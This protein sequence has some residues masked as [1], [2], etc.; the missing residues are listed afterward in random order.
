MN[1]VIYIGAVEGF[2]AAKSVLEDIAVIR[3]V[4]ADQDSVAEAMQEAGALLDASMKVRITDEMIRSAPGLKVISCAT[5]GSD[6]IERRVLDVRGI[7]VHT[8]RDDPD[9]IKNITPAAELS[10]ALLMACARRLPAAVRHVADG[11]WTREQFPGVMLKGRRL[12]L[13]GCGR[14]GGWMARYARAF[15]MEAVGCDPHL[16]AW[17][18]NIRKVSLT[19]L[20]QTSDFISVHVHLTDETRGLISRTLIEKIKPGAVF[21]NTSRGAI[22]DENALLDELKSGRIHGVGLDVLTG[23]PDVA[24]HPLVKYSREH[25]NVLITP[26]CGGFS[27]DA[28]RVVCAHAAGKIRAALTDG[29]GN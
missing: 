26:H 25:D 7:S 10:W 28:V 22:T 18:D 6:H 14:I 8:L 16:K 9:V 24:E 15:G 2:E 5:T 12:G 3:H 13:I 19:E 20:M 11:G 29:G 1:K 27:P 21:I 23:E 4:E 17:P